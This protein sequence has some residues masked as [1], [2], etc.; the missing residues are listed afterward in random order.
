M[1]ERELWWVHYEA[2]KELPLR[3][4]HLQRLLRIYYYQ[5]CLEKHHLNKQV[6]HL[7][8]DLLLKYEGN[9]M[10]KKTIIKT[11]IDTYH[12]AIQTIVNR[13]RTF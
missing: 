11:H 1:S 13:D 9:I 4:W 7:E 6:N 10:I 2:N 3:R 8:L 5:D 12:V